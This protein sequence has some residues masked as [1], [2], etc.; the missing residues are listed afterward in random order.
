MTVWRTDDPCP[1]C[2]AGLFLI[3]HG[4]PLQVLE[5]WL[6]GWSERWDLSADTEGGSGGDAA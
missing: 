6:C 5:C 3:G 1:V 4:E 2:A